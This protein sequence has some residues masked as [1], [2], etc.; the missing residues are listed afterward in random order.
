MNVACEQSPPVTRIRRRR[1]QCASPSLDAVATP[2]G[3]MAIAGTDWLHS[4]VL[5]SRSVQ[6]VF[7]GRDRHSISVVSS[8]TEQVIVYSVYEIER[9]PD[10]MLHRH[11]A[12]G[13]TAVRNP[14]GIGI[15]RCF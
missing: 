5:T 8:M 14:M 1:A 4:P 15:R 2:N 7:A 11:T 10:S 9:H 3:T 13:N 6:D 12:N